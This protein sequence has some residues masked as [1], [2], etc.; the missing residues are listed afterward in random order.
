M[1]RIT[2][3][4]TSITRV[5]TTVSLGD[6]LYT[7]DSSPVVALYGNVPEWRSLS[8]SSTAGADISQLQQSLIALGYD[9]GKTVTVNATFDS[10]TVAMVERWQTGLGLPATGKIALGSIVFMPK[11]M[12]VQA[13][14]HVVG[15]LV[16]DDEAMVTL[17]GSTQQVVMQVPSGD[18]Q[19]FVP[20]LA[21]QLTGGGTGK[22]W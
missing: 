11:A 1:T 4:V 16:G 15:D 7:I 20:G 13:V 6:V 14:S 3:T 9:P 8:S 5:G 2:Q 17:Q 19:Y 12:L 10:A 22:A 18:E 21:V